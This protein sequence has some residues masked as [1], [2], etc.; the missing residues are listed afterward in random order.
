MLHILKGQL[1]GMDVNIFQ[2]NVIKRAIG[3]FF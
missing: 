1:S 3:F 2:L